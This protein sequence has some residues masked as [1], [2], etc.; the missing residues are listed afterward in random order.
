MKTSK[1][2]V[3]MCAALVAVMV[4]SDRVRAEDDPALALFK[5]GGCD[6][7]HSISA[8][9]IAKAEKKP[10]EAAAPEEKP[11]ATGAKKKDA[12][13][14]SGVGLEHDAKWISGYINKTESKDGEKHEKRF[15]GTEP[16]R[17]TLAMWLA[18]LKHEVKKPAA[19]DASTPKKD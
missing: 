3:V 15:K 10:G 2:V 18:G 7:C 11:A 14:L 19:E 4:S 5:K 6:T 16:E 17:R 9:K 8:L 1:M 13:D 12:P